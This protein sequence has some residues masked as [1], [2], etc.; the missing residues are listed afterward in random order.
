MKSACAVKDIDTE[1][2]NFPK[3]HTYRNI[4]TAAK[5]QQKLEVSCPRHIREYCAIDNT[6]FILYCVYLGQFQ[7]T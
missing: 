2:S 1:N 6:I 3:L 7:Y 5:M 4:Y